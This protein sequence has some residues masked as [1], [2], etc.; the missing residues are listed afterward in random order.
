MRHGRHHAALRQAQLPGQGRQ[1]SGRDDEKGLLHRATG[2][3]G[4]VLVDIPKDITIARA[5]YEYPHDVDMRSY[6]PVVKG[7]Q[8][9]IKK[10]VQ[11]LL[12]PSARWSTPA[13]A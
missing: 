10:A 5:E 8:G 13:A 4:P 7:H 1:R 2:R 12:R 3:P 9:Q 6:K 11:L